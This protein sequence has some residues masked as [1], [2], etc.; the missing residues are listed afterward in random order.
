MVISKAN[1]N[2]LKTALPFP[3]LNPLLSIR[4]DADSRIITGRASSH[5]ICQSCTPDGP[6][7]ALYTRLSNT[8][9]ADQ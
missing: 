3:R 6:Y 4:M 5:T 1:Y 2:S 8:T 7:N 9:R